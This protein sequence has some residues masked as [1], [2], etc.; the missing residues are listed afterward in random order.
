MAT[1]TRWSEDEIKKLREYFPNTHWDYLLRL[2]PGRSKDAIKTRAYKIGLCRSGY[3]NQTCPECGG[4]KTPLSMVCYQCWARNAKARKLAETVAFMVEMNSDAPEELKRRTLAGLTQWE[5]LVFKESS[6]GHDMAM[7]KMI[8]PKRA[9]WEIRIIAEH[10]G[11]SIE[12]DD[13]G[14]VDLTGK[15]TR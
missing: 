4:D 15:I 13:L 11:C 1:T 6:I 2:F 10:C 5:L 14:A 3:N 8:M 12:E 7:L 9:K